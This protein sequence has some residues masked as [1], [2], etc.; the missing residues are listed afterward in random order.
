MSYAYDTYA[1]ANGGMA[2]VQLDGYLWI[3]EYLAWN[4]DLGLN[5]IGDK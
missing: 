4:M 5:G 3:L 2:S 1:Y